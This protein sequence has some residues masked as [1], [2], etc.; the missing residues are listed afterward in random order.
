MFEQTDKT[1][2]FTLIQFHVHTIS[3]PKY[4]GLK[5]NVYKTIT[6]VEYVMVV[7]LTLHLI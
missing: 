7:S 5:I 2:A 4:N 1:N 6:L 3:N